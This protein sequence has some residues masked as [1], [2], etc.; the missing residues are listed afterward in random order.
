MRVYF[1][2]SST[3]A[4]DIRWNWTPSV[5]TW[6]HFAFA[7]DPEQSTNADRSRF[8]LNGIDQGDGTVTTAGLALPLK[9]PTAGQFGIGNFDKTTQPFDG[10]IDDV[11][12]YS[13]QRTASQ[14]MSDYTKD[15]DASETNSWWR[16]DNDA[17]VDQT[18]NSYDLSTTGSPLFSTTV[19]SV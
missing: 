8:I 10:L 16:F 17:W 9:V 1:F 5:N 6:Y 13:S 14:V 12:T 18:S 4:T 2:N 19:P 15:I 7:I 3:Q 11:R